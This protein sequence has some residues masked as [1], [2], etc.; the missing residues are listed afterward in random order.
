MD[1]GGAAEREEAGEGEGQDGLDQR[2]AS[3]AGLPFNT[4]STSGP[5]GNRKRAGGSAVSGAFCG[6][7]P[8]AARSSR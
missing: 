4:P 2:E 3:A 6:N 7:S 1:G 8:A 5:S